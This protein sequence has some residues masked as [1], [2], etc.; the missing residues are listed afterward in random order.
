MGYDYCGKTRRGYDL[1]RGLKR[2]TSRDKSLNELSE[3]DSGPL[4][5]FKGEMGLRRSASDI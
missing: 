3:W 4:F 1:A 2:R 5:P